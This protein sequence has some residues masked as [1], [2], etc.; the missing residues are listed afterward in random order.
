VFDLLARLSAHPS[1]PFE[2]LVGA[3]RREVRPGTTVVVVSAR[4]PS[5]YLAHLRRLERA[6]WP[7]VLV[8]CGRESV[9]DAGRARAAG[10]TARSARLDGPWRTAKGLAVS[11]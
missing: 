3:I 5:P 1:A 7:V 8:A 2:R 4:D 6:G 10:L 11:G 9:A